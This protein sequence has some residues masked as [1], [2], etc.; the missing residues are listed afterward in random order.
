MQRMN[1][2]THLNP[3]AVSS[4]NFLQGAPLSSARGTLEVG[5]PGGLGR[6][7]H[8]QFDS[9]GGPSTEF[10]H[11]HECLVFDVSCALGRN[12]TSGTSSV[13]ETMQANFLDLVPR[14][15]S[16]DAL[17][18]SLGWR[19]GER[20]NPPAPAPAAAAGTLC[21]PNTSKVQQ[22]QKMPRWLVGVGD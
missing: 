15:Q 22:P 2:C 7:T 16:Q 21:G 10:G 5:G 3:L 4:F 1:S 18:E 17:S 14:R 11:D 9:H 8:R 19:K 13:D 6:T 12:K 20:R